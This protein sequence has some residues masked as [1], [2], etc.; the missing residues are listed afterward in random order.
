VRFDPHADRS[1]E[2]Q[3][4]MNDHIFAMLGV[5]GDRFPDTTITETYAV[6]EEDYETTL[7]AEVA[8]YQALEADARERY[9]DAGKGVIARHCATELAARV[10]VPA[11]V[12]TILEHV[13]ALVPV[14]PPVAV[15][16]MPG[17]GER[18]VEEIEPDDE[19]PF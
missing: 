11:S 2:D 18:E 13:R 16:V 6:W 9:G 19:I 8:D 1:T 3:A 14:I 4:E 5:D 15:E 12:Q 7:R 17:D 10:E